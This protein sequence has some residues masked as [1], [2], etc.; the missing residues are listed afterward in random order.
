VAGQVLVALRDDCE[1]P[2][3]LR[4]LCAIVHG[5]MV[6]KFANL[7]DADADQTVGWMLFTR[8]ICAA[9]SEVCTRSSSFALSHAH[10]PDPYGMG[11]TLAV[12]PS[13]YELLAAKP[14]VRAAQHLQQIGATLRG[15]IYRRALPATD[16]NEP[17]NLFIASRHATKTVWAQALAACARPHTRFIVLANG[18]QKRQRLLRAP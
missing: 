16:E 2:Q 12:Q 14:G 15:L 9:L 6:S 8:F 11:A 13:E 1:M 18:A 4:T 3:Q 17:S 7:T 5:E 10:A